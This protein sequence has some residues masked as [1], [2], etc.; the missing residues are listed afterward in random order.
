MAV[1]ADI[2]DEAV[3]LGGVAEDNVEIIAPI[4]HAGAVFDD[5]GDPDDGA[6]EL[7]HF[8]GELV[9]RRDDIARGR[10][11]DRCTGL[12]ERVLHIDDQER[13]PFR[14][15][16]IEQMQAIAFGDDTLD[17][18]LTDLDIMHEVASL[19]ASRLAERLAIR[20]GEV[21]TAGARRARPNQPS[22]SAASPSGSVIMASCPVA[23]SW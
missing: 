8:A 13:G 19:M 21:E 11:F 2:V 4:L 10:D 6:A 16:R 5:G 15:E 9:D 12:A 17:D 18:V 3:E 1:T 22:N 14:I 23:R 20:P 7:A